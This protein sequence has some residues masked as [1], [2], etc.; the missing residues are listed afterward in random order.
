M[1]GRRR[2]RH[3]NAPTA[4]CACDERAACLIRLALQSLEEGR[5]ARARWFLTRLPYAL[6]AALDD[7]YARGRADEWDEAVDRWFDG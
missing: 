6:K 3:Q 4:A 1:G 2:E 7:A 5:P